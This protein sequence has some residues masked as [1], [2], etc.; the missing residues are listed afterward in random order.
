MRSGQEALASNDPF[1]KGYSISF[2]SF[3]SRPEHKKPP[4]ED[5]DERQCL[6]AGRPVVLIKTRKKETSTR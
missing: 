3:L 4:A 5:H 1:A 6:S 2:V